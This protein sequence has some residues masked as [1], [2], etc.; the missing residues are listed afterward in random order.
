MQVKIIVENNENNKTFFIH[1][2]RVFGLLEHRE[3]HSRCFLLASVRNH[4]STASPASFHERS[5]YGESAPLTLDCS[6][7]RRSSSSWSLDL[8]GVWLDRRTCWDRLHHRLHHRLHLR[9]HLRQHLRLHLWLHHLWI[10]LVLNVER[11]HRLLLVERRRSGADG[12][13]SG[14]HRSR[15]SWWENK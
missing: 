4:I 10:P 3:V 12:G 8:W 14:Q 13:V 15:G 7:S 11:L 5:V 1:S 2:K 9:L 6:L